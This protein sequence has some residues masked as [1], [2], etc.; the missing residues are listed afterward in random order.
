MKIIYLHNKI[1]FFLF[2]FFPIFSSTRV[3]TFPQPL[4]P[5]LHYLVTTTTPPPCPPRH[6]CPLP[7][8]IPSEQKL[9]L[10]KKKNHRKGRTQKNQ[11]TMWWPTPISTKP[12]TV[13]HAD[14]A[15]T[16]LDLNIGNIRRPTTYFSHN[17]ITTQPRPTTQT[18]N[19]ATT[20]FSRTHLF[21]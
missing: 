21:L 17:P 14:L 13:T 19:P 5:H 16:L 9:I 20:H 6:H 4:A 11:P 18:P 7:T 10:K 15:M 8:K 12:I 3:C 2:C 1:Y